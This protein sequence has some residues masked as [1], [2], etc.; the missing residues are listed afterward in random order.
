MT[1]TVFSTSTAATVL[2]VLQFFL[3]AMEAAVMVLY[4]VPLGKPLLQ[5][6]VV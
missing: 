6:L 5:V 3:A 2:P 4:V 1:A